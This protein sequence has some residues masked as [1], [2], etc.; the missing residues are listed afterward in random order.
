MFQIDYETAQKRIN[1]LITTVLPDFYLDVIINPRM[2]YEKLVSEFD[3]VYKR[4]GG[5]LL[6]PK[7]QF[8][9][10]GNGG[11]VA[12]SFAGLG[13]KSFFLSKTSPLGKVLIDFYMLPLGVNLI[14]NQTGEM[15]SSVIF[16]I[17]TEGQKNNVML[18]SAGSVANFSSDVLT[19]DQWDTL[20]QSDVIVIT[21][22]QNL[23]LEDLAEGILNKIQGKGIISIDFSDLTPHKHRIDAFHNK[24]L[25]HPK[26]IPDF[27]MGNEN[28]FLLLSRDSASSPSLA[29]KA[30]SQDYPS[31]KFGLHQAK[32]AE[33]WQN[34]EKLAD[35]SCFEIQVL[36]ATGAGDS[37]HAGFLS[38]YKMGF[39]YSDAIK[40]AN[41]VAGYKISTGKVA[42]LRELYSFVEY[43]K[44]YQ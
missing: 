7:V 23:V 17:P 30:L 19:Q 31:I 44:Q 25:S 16:E 4:G 41:A 11:N 32:H 40:F 36:F 2:P 14:T 10:G 27:I 35:E 18:S 33:L 22:A 26:R 39:N 42:T 21:N 29:T 28:E 3:S 1:A 13:A 24:I 5:N 38:A 8:I 34:G 6:G 9:P 15:A 12:I 37:W 20:T 43:T